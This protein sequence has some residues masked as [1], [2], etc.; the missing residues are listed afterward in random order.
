MPLIL[1]SMAAYPTVQRA[2]YWNKRLFDRFST[3]TNVRAVPRRE[4][5]LLVGSRPNIRSA[6]CGTAIGVQEARKRRPDLSNDALLVLAKEVHG[7]STDG[8]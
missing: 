7:L 3:Q 5:L 1:R 6:P 2:A 8:A 4:R